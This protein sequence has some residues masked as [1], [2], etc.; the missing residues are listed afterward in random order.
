MRQDREV[1]DEREA[2]RK[3]LGQGEDDLSEEVDFFQFLRE[4]TATYTSTTHTRPRSKS[5][6]KKKRNH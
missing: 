1:G 5:D 3:N 6:P 4:Y 2:M